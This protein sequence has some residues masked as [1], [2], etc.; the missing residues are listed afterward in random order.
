MAA[1][2]QERFELLGCI[3]CGRCTAGCPVSFRTY[4]NIRKVVYEGLTGT[5]PKDAR[6]RPE[7]W[8]CTTC[9]NCTE[10]CPKGVKPMELLIG[11]RSA[12]Q[13]R[14]PVGPRT[15]EADGMGRRAISAR[16][17]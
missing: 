8:N 12:V 3:Q 7:A 2:L 11:L 5:G 6:G 16:G 14:E 17:G 4:L 15:R 10:R 13:A 1:S 9:S